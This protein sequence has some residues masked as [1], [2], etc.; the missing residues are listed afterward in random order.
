MSALL[1]FPAQTATLDTLKSAIPDFAKDIRLNLGSI[2]TPEGAPD[3]TEVQ[4]AGTALAVAY[5]LNHPI[6]TA[7]IEGHVA[8]LLT[9]QQKTAAKTAAS[10][11]A[12]NN[13]Y[14][15]FLHYVENDAVKALPAKLR[16]QGLATHGIEKV[17]FELMSLAVS[18]ITGCG[19]CMGAH[20]KTLTDHGVSA[21]GVQ[22]AVRIAAVL[23]AARQSLSIPA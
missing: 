20:A 18:A 4:I 13:I 17:D 7:A 15:R 6:V 3:L 10:L 16:M 21:L 5:A 2:L 19:M 23:H 9:D 22:S 14:Y 11:M 12:M 8:A 1:D